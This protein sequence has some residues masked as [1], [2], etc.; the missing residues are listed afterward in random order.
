MRIFPEE[1]RNIMDVFHLRQ[2]L[3]ADYK[4]Y[5][6]SF[7]KILDPRIRDY[8][9]KELDSG[10]LW[11]DPLLQLNPRFDQ[12]KTVDELSAE[13]RLHSLNSEIFRFGKSEN[14]HV[15]SSAPLHKHQSEA[16]EAASSGDSY[17]LKTGTGSGKS[18][19][20]IIPIVDYALK[21][22]DKKGI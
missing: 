16:I 20:Y 8:V 4:A 2:E 1:E 12:G 21:N 19:A 7:I 15:G 14:D 10:A 22:K 3:T 18:L 11:P 6:E 5:T 9:E 13:G 17:V